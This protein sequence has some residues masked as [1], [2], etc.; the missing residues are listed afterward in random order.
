MQ[1][2]SNFLYLIIGPSGVGKGSIIRSLKE[3]DLNIFFPV[4]YTTRPMREGEKE[5]ETYHFIDK[6]KF[7]SMISNQDFLEYALVHQKA[8]YGTDKASIT[9]ALQN[10]QDVLREIDFQGYESIK[11][12]IPKSQLKVFYIDAGSWENLKERITNRSQISQEEIEKR[13]QSFLIE[14]KYKDEADYVI[15]NM[16]GQL[17]EAIQKVKDIILNNRNN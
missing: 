1:D 11:K 16:N 10:G 4:S 3:S 13:H 6:E 8:Y 5:G 12:L 15:S 7:E 17:E 2:L 9:N 14:E